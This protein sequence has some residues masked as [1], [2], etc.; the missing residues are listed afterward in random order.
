MLRVY[1]VNNYISTLL[2]NLCRNIVVPEILRLY[3]FLYACSCESIPALRGSHHIIKWTVVV[4]SWFHLWKHKR[5]RS[6]LSICNSTRRFRRSPYI[7]FKPAPH[8]IESSHHHKQSSSAPSSSQTSQIKVVL[9]Y[10]WSWIVFKQSI[11]LQRHIFPIY[12]LKSLS[13]IFLLL[14]GDQLRCRFNFFL[15]DCA[16]RRFLSSLILVYEQRSILV[17]FL[18]LSKTFIFGKCHIGHLFVLGRSIASWATKTLRSYC[19]NRY[20]A[21]AQVFWLRW[22]VYRNI[23]A[24]I[25]LAKIS[26]TLTAE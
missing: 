19:T 25:F 20:T 22:L 26:V 16:G 10:H 2:H 18:L 6:R 11:K 17:F 9:P 5:L 8:V 24:Y 23:I 15:H 13:E 21:L 7:L 12:Q 3:F 4:W 1:W 14:L